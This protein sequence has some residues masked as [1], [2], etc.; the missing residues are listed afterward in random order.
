[1]AARLLLS[2]SMSLKASYAQMTQYLHLLT[3]AGLGLP[4]DLWVPVTPSVRPEQSYLYSVGAA[5]NL[6]SEY[7]FSIEG[8]YKTMTGLIEY[9]EGASYTDIENDWQTKITSGNG[10]SYGAEFFLQKKTGKLNGWIGY[11]LSWNY[12]KFPEINEGKR[13]PYKYDRRHDVEVALAYDL[14]ENK[15]LSLTWVYGTGTAISLANLTYTGAD[16][17]EWENDIQYYEGRNNYRMKAYHRL[18]LSYTVKK[19]TKWGE[20]SWSYSIYNVYSRRNPFF[21]DI[22]YDKQ[23][24][25][26]FIQY[27]LFPIIPSVA[28]HFKF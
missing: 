10:E 1:V 25:K 24:H 17:Y 20:K 9:K 6:N 14:A 16:P 18:D 22:G 23:G 21:M 11:T 19:K 2:R 8:Y 28:F 5:Y 13:F 15:D 3:N 27:S 12:R 26:K 7:E 4:T